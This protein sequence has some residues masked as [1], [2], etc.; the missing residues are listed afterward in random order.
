VG[1][2]GSFTKDDA[3]NVA[4][5]LK[6]RYEEGRRPHTLAIIYYKGVRVTQ[7][8]IRR[9]SQKDQ[10]HGHLP[11]AL[12]LS[13]SQTRK[14]ADCTLSYEGWIELM[15]RKNKISAQDDEIN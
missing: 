10:G 13:A 2:S 6:A 1:R 12:F 14:L 8:G 15:K 4:A 3:E 5:K 11:K 9:G 7:F